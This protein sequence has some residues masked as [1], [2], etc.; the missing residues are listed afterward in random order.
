MFG[1][2]IVAQTLWKYQTT[3]RLDLRHKMEPMPDTALV[4]K[5]LRLARPWAYGEN[6]ML[7][8]S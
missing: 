8:F 7:V 1:G 6:Q 4:T 2:V 3:L 5:N